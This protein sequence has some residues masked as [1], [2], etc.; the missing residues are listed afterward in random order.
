[1]NFPWHDSATSKENLPNFRDS[2]SLNMKK[3]MKNIMV[4]LQ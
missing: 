1:M 4:M 2:P 3:Y